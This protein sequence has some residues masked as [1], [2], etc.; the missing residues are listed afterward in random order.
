MRRGAGAPG[1]RLTGRR[2]G[3]K[4]VRQE[5]GSAERRHLEASLRQI[6]AIVLRSKREKM[7]M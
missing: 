2:T 1:F 4:P 7:A 5:P 3:R 6:P